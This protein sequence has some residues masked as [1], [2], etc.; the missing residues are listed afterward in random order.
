[1]NFP[2]VKIDRTTAQEWLPT[3][4]NKGIFSNYCQLKTLDSIIEEKK[5]ASGGAPLT[6]EQIR[7]ACTQAGEYR[8]KRFVFHDYGNYAIG[9]DIK[10][11]YEFLNQAEA[12]LSDEIDPEKINHALRQIHLYK[13]GHKIAMIILSEAYKQRKYEELTISKADIVRYLGYNTEDKQIYQDIDE[14][15]FSLRWLNYIFYQYRTTKKVGK[16]SMTTGNFI[17][18]LQDDG[19][20]YTVWI[21]KVFLGCIEFVLCDE[22]NKLAD[23]EKKQAFSRGYYGYD[24][25]LLPMMRNYSTPAYLLSHFLVLD[26]G[27]A[28]LNT[29]ENKIVAYK[30]SRFMEEAGIRHSRPSKRKNAFIKALQEVTLI[31]RTEPG[32]EELREVKPGDIEEIALR[33]YIK[34]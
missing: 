31:N 2:I 26:S 22:T 10:M 32:I 19:K 15:M 12:Y 28:K 16:N 24:T 13:L 11:Y 25:A 7:E 18:N 34:K 17:Y 27:N 9:F 23:G 20:S 29:G 14:A 3:L 6:N 30:I 8:T 21:N 5:A 4:M 33:V 1:M